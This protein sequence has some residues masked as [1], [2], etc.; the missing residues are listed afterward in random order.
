[1]PIGGFSGSDPAPTIT[2]FKS[3]VAAGKVHYFV[4]G[5]AFGQPGGEPGRSN[6]ISAWV[7]SHFT[8]QTVDEVTLYDLTKPKSSPTS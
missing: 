8:A 6:T 1:M 5:G 4:G 7:T 2:Q 3:Y